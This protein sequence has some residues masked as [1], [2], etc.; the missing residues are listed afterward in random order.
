MSAVGLTAFPHR[1][2]PCIAEQGA[3]GGPAGQVVPRARAWAPCCVSEPGL[4][5][6]LPVCDGCT[7]LL[8]FGTLA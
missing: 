4:Q 1:I 7:H 8:P 6:S 2:R 3:A 5:K